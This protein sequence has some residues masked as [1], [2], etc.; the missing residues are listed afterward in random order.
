MMIPSLPLLAVIKR[1]TQTLCSSRKPSGFDFLLCSLVTQSHRLRFTHTGCTRSSKSSAMQS[2]SSTIRTVLFPRS[3]QLVQIQRTS[4]LISSGIRKP[5]S[6]RN[7][8][9]LPQTKSNDRRTTQYLLH[10]I[11]T[12]SCSLRDLKANPKVK[13]LLK[14]HH[15][16][17]NDHRWNE[18]EWDTV[19]LGFVFGIDP[20]FYDVDQATA[21]ITAYLQKEFARNKI[22]QFRLVFASLKVKFGRNSYSAKAYAIESQRSTCREMISILK[23]V[24]K[25]TGAFVPIQM[26]QKH[27]DA[28]QKL[29]RA[30]TRI[31]S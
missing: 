8:N 6:K 23:T 11:R 22:P 19:Q 28:F 4:K 7:P 31:L 26:R 2:R 12:S 17:V 14:L 30:Q 1:E 21:K 3:I 29:T 9:V 25:T 18:T 27:P 5:A 24:F 20:S 13:N 10:R 16:Y 15:F